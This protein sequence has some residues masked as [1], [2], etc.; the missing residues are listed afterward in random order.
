MPF[1]PDLQKRA[2][3]FLRRAIPAELQSHYAPGSMADIFLTHCAQDRPLDPELREMAGIS[4]L[5]YDH[6]IA[7]AQTTELKAYYAECQQLLR[8]I[9]VSSR[10]HPQGDESSDVVARLCR[11]VQKRQKMF[12]DTSQAE[13]VWSDGA[14]LEVGTSFPSDLRKLIS[15]PTHHHDLHSFVKQ[16]AT[17]RASPWRDATVSPAARDA[18][19]T[20]IQS[21]DGKIRTSVESL[22]V[23]YLTQRYPAA[24]IQ[25]RGEF[26]PVLFVVN[27]KVRASLMP[28]KF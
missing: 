9:A 19:Y 22:Y 5:E 11:H 3:D 10:D 24:M 7:N 21:S 26:E 4:A 20:H 12:V 18:R 28:V 8:E 1:P 16:L 25:V 6:A 14:L 23:E 17:A 15:R 13:I 27:G 2:T